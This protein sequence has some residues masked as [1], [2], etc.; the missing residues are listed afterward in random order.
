MSGIRKEEND[1]KKTLVAFFSASGTTRKTAETL[2][3]AIGAELYEIRPA[4]AYT[5]ADLNWRDRSSR[6]SREMLDP[7]A[8]PRLADTDAAVG[9]YDQ[10]FLGFPIWWDTA[11]AIIRSFLE[12]YDFTGKTIILFA[13]SGGSGMGKTAEDLSGCCPGALIRE[14]KVLNGNPDSDT[15]R[16]WAMKFLEVKIEKCAR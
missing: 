7:S 13:T 14:G 3:D 8:R 16:K 12:S 4:E 9:R 5:H 10:I 6:S 2:A 1:I 15:L 11:P